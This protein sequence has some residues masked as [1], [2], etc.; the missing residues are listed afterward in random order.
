MAQTLLLDVLKWDLA[1]DAAGNIA[2]ASEPYSLAQDAA[3]AIKTFSGQVYFDTSL[4]VPY[5]SQILGQSP[6]LSL[7]KASFVQAALTVPG[8]VTAQC[9]ITSWVDRVISGQVQVTDAA[10]NISAAG[11]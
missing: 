1:A 3:S 9:F 4:G 2:V 5:F 6:P 7:I 11:F 8:V 10:G